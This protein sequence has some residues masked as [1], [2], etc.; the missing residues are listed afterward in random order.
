[1][2]RR[3]V[4][5]LFVAPLVWLSS[6]VTALADDLNLPDPQWFR[7]EVPSMDRGSAVLVMI[8]L[9]NWIIGSLGF[10]MLVY[11]SFP[12]VQY[13][14]DMLH[15]KQSKDSMRSRG[16]SLLAGVMLL[17]FSLTGAWYPLLRAIVGGIARTLSGLG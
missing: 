17:L 5:S 16:I 7:P 13:A 3:W 1:M 6:A 10:L 9:L 2:Q 15:G 4:P 12:L 14:W 11:A 8:R